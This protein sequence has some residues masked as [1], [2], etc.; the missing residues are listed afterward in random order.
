MEKSKVCIFIP[1]YYP[2]EAKR[3]AARVSAHKIQMDW[4]EQNMPEVNVLV[5]A[6]NYKDEDY[7]L[8]SNP[9]VS[10]IKH[11]TGIGL[12]A[13]RNELF[14]A[15]YKSDYEWGIFTDDD[16]VPLKSDLIMEFFKRLQ[17]PAN[18]GYADI[19]IPNLLWGDSDERIARREDLKVYMQK[20]TMTFR[21]AQKQGLHWMIVRNPAKKGIEIFHPLW[22]TAHGE[23][24]EDMQ[25]CIDAMLAGL[26]MFKAN[27]FIVR[28]PNTDAVSSTIFESG[29]ERMKYHIMSLK[30]LNARYEGTGI[31]FRT[32]HGTYT[33]PFTENSWKAIEQKYG[34]GETHKERLLNKSRKLF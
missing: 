19:I 34:V 31:E 7:S 24:Y 10:Y 6:Q 28:V 29:R 21:Q 14:E 33:A 18:F 17:V 12:C 8:T 23:G 22:D 5:V 26:K 13:A 3:K 32:D 16:C 30:A 9:R 2:T 15:F 11:E 25:F 27:E 20:D 4:I 1:S